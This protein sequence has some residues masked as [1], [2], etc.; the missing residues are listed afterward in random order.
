MM[1]ETMTQIELTELVCPGCREQVGPE[2]PAGADDQVSERW[3]HRDGSPLCG[4][5]G[6]G[7]VEPVECLN[8]P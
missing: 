3:S 8:Q 2:P 1:A 7:P 4:T 6:A 5:A